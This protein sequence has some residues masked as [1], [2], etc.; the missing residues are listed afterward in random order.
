MEYGL[1]NRK[2][3]G[4]IYRSSTRSEKR[5]SGMQFENG[6]RNWLLLVQFAGGAFH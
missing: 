4:P 3:L 2:K 6:L 5:K 1:E